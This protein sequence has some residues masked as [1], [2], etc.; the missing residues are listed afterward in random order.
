MP[1]FPEDSGGRGDSWWREECK[2][3]TEG[4]VNE[5]RRACRSAEKRGFVECRH[6]SR[7]A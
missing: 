7:K 5:F 2:M 1:I 4:M 6:T 3:L